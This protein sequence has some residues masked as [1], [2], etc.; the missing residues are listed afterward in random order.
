MYASKRTVT[1]AS[2][3]LNNHYKPK[4]HRANKGGRSLYTQVIRDKDSGLVVKTITHDATGESVFNLKKRK[5]RL[6]KSMS[7]QPK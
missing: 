5:R 3:V 1:K 4:S 2:G 7:S 6:R